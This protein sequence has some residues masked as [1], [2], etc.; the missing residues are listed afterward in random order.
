[1]RPLAPV[2]P[3]APV[4][5]LALLAAGCGGGGGSGSSSIRTL[6][7]GRFVAPVVAGLPYSTPTESGVTGSDGSFRY[8]AGESI[9]FAIG[10]TPLGASVP[11]APELDAFALVPGAEPPL[12]ARE[13]D[14]F[15]NEESY[16]PPA[17]DVLRQ[18]EAVNLLAFLFAFDAD[19]DPANGVAL[20][21]GL[22]ARFAAATLDFRM[23]SERFQRSY[24][25]RARRYD[26]FH[27]GLV[28]HAG[29]FP[30]WRALELHCA[31][32]G[33]VPQAWLQTRLERDGD[34]DG[35]PDQRSEL[36]LDARFAPAVEW[37]DFDA[38]GTPDL[39]ESWSF[40][41]AGRLEAFALDGDGDGFPERTEFRSYGLHDVVRETASDSDGD[42]SPD[43][44]TE[45]EYGSTG[46]LWRSAT[47]ADG[48]G[49]YDDVV[50]ETDYDALGRP[51]EQRRDFDGDGA[52]DFVEQTVFDAAGN[53]IESRSD[54]DGDGQFDFADWSSYD[55]AGNLLV[56]DSDHDGD[57]APD[58]RVAFEYDAAGNTIR[59]RTDVDF[60]GQFD[61]TETREVDA[62][63]RLLRRESDFDGDGTVDDAD[64][65]AYVDDA[66]GNELERRDD[67]DADGDVD[68]RVSREFGAD[69]QLLE[70]AFDVGGDG[71]TDAIDRVTMTRVPLAS[72]RLAN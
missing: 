47:D 41:A 48:D 72:W 21:P 34:A 26:A 33:L 10:A 67:W 40:D 24:P 62:R 8:R 19:R 27:A 51:I 12:A 4:A 16:R 71:V 32:L 55:A 36:L 18:Y 61:S 44:W 35:L 11:A 59:T 53:A 9:T 6:R 5:L 2:A 63:R 45:H 42:G 38:D 56:R 64:A 37:I 13:I 58:Y 23:A 14:R 69:G 20:A 7:V 3:I 54:N 50:H 43:S 49:K 28:A 52:F 68:Y 29:E 66:A 15:R 65:F 17:P 70:V 31:E 22:A 57:G 1:M 25:F 39:I 46:L 60:D 30:G